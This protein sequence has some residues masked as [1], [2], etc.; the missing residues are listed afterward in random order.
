MTRSSRASVRVEEEDLDMED[1]EGETDDDLVAEDAQSEAD[2]EGQE[3]DEEGPS[4]IVGAV[5]RK[6]RSVKSAQRKARDDASASESGSD[7]EDISQD[8]DESTPEAENDW[9]GGSDVA[10]EDD[11]D[12]G[13]TGTNRCV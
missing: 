6:T 8:S 11:A 9:E 10:E 4:E 12:A 5:K 2:A 3:D 1:A 7:E 13:Q